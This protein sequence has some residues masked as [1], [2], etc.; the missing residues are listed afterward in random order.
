MKVFVRVFILLV[1]AALLSCSNP[2][3]APLKP[4]TLAASFRTVSTIAGDGTAGLRDGAGVQARFNNPHGVAVDSW[5]NVYV[6]DYGNHRIR[7]IEPTG[8]VS[9]L[10]GDGPNK[11]TQLILPNGVATD[12]LSN[13]YV[14]EFMQHRI[15]KITP[16]GVMSNFAGRLNAAGPGDGTG[17]Q[18]WF[19]HP[20]DVAVDLSGNVYVAEQ[21]QIRKIT[22]ERV[23]STIAG[24]NGEGEYGY[25]DGYGYGFFRA[26]T[27]NLPNLALFAFPRSLAVNSSG[28]IYVA[29]TGNH[30]IRKITADGIVSTIADKGVA[31]ILKNPSGIAV[32]SFGSLYVADTGNHRILKFTPGG[33][34]SVIAGDG[35]AGFRGGT[36]DQARFNRPYGVAVDSSGNVYVADSGNNRIRKII[37][38]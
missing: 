12:S 24:G 6:A 3:N 1:V 19:F 15:M 21:S 32:D 20:L 4:S 17:E 26:G 35:T 31:A 9:T 38:R 25:R 11:H 5:G 7:K 37:R 10:A 33:G 36:G 28:T 23:A 14:A 29:D 18:A 16:S 27:T 2:A 34:V 22:P 30:R 13:V 8:R